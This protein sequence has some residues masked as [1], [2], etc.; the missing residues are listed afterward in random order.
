MIPALGHSLDEYDTI[1]VAF[2]GGK[3]SLACVLRLLDLGARRSQIE[4]WHH[5]VDGGDGE[6]FMDWPVTRAYCRAVARELQLPIY[7]SWREGGFLREMLRD[8]TPTAPVTF[9]TGPRARTGPRPR[10][11]V[12]GK[13]PAG[14][15]RK[16]PQVSADLS[17][18]WCSAYL[19]IDVAARALAND[20][21]FREGRFLFVTGER[22]EESAARARYAEVEAHRAQNRRRR[23]TQW[24]AVIDMSEREVWDLIQKHGVRPHPAYELG[25]GR[26]SCVACIFGGADQWAAVREL[27]PETFERIARLEEEFGAT[28]QRRASVRELAARGRSLVAG[29]P[30]RLVQLG[31]GKTYD[32]ELRREGEW[33]LPAGAYKSCG[34]PT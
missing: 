10:T 1:I 32:E 3:D 4:L 12:G 30:E 6:H 22:R 28:I 25:F 7:F 27:L 5:D 26:V 9:E 33:S 8:G 13:G 20:P 18:R 24:R 21:R 34:G 17:V 15:R 23:V 14:R 29:A 19:K 2:S 31:R 11:T 16:F